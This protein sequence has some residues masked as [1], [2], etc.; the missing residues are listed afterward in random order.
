MTIKIDP[1][2]ES[3]DYN[4]L[5]GLQKSFMINVCDKKFKASKASNDIDRF[6]DYMKAYTNQEDEFYLVSFNDGSMY[7]VHETLLE[8]VDIKEA[9]DK[10]LKLDKNE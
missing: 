6:R 5:T 4:K 2:D 9:L 1:F 7:Y 10:V 8:R 3:I